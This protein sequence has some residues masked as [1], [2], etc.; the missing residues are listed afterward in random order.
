MIEPSLHPN[1]EHIAFLLGTWRGEG[2]GFY[3]TI[4]DFVYEEESRFWHVGK[5]FLAYSQRTWDPLSGA[6]LHS[7]TGYWRCTDGGDIEVVLAH[8]FGY[9]EIGM[10]RA[11]G[12]HI[13]VNS[14][15]LVPTPSAKD[16]ETVTRSISVDGNTLT[17]EI[18]MAAQGQTLQGHLEATLLR[19]P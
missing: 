14:A 17:Y 11:D 13:E 7:E 12:S 1:C 5:P 19:V 2:K 18:G 10:G 3:P 15:A 9:A 6:P 8:P 16:I 4:T